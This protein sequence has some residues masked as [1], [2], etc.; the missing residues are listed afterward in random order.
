MKEAFLL[1]FF[2]AVVII[3]WVI[4]KNNNE[5]FTNIH[6]KQANFVNRQLA[7]YGHVPIPL[8]TSKK[9]G[10]LGETGNDMLRTDDYKA[11]YPLT[12]KDG[13]WKIVD[14][15]E[16]IKV[17]DCSAFDDPEFSLNCGICLD[18][19]KN[20]ANAPAVGG[21]VLLPA[22]KKAARDGN[23]SNFIPEYVPTL[24][25]CPA[26]KLVST[27]EECLQAQ[28]EI[29]CEKNG[30]FDIPGCA[31][32][33]SDGKFSIVDSDKPG[34]VSGYGRILVV[35]VGILTIR[36]EGFD[37]RTNINLS[38][39]KS[40][41]FDIRATEGKTVKFSLTPP[42]KSTDMN[43][44]NPYIAG[45]MIGRT[46]AGEWTQ[47]LRQIVIIDE[48]TGRKPRSTGAQLLN[49]VN[50]VKMAP[51]FGQTTMTISLSIPF[52]F[53][54][55]T[56]KEASLCKGSPFITSQASANF[57]ES[58]PC[59]NKGSGPGKYSQECLQNVWIT[60]GC[61]ISGKSYPND[62][63]TNAILMTAED[64]SF[65]TINDI[66]DYIYNLAIITATG[67]DQSG[68]KQSIDGWSNASYECTGNIITSPCDLPNSR[69]NILSPDC[70]IYLWNNQ[71][72]KKLWN[73][74][75]SPIGPTYYTSDAVSLFKRGSTLRACQT[76]GTLS[77]VSPNGSTKN[78]IVAYWQSKGDLNTVKKLMADL[79]RAANAQA[80]ADDKLAPYF[81]QC[82][83]NVDFAKPV[84]YV[85][86]PPPP[87][88]P[89]KTDTVKPY[90]Q[91]L[92][93]IIAQHCDN[94][95]WKR[96]LGLGSWKSI[97]HY[98]SDISYITV[99]IGITANLTTRQG[100]SH[101]IYGPGVFNFCTKGGFNDNV[102]DILVTRQ[103]E[104]GNSYSE[105]STVIIA[106]HCNNT[107]WKKTFGLGTWKSVTHYPSD[108]SYITV[109]IGMVANL[110][111]RQGLS[112]TVY[113]PGEFNFCT[114][115]GFNDNVSSILI[116]RQARF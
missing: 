57:L 21:L 37:P 81:T 24:G 89:P 27:K 68:K 55:T 20:H 108:V 59:Y 51:G 49:G 50:T 114:K 67:I 77:P 72:S 18:I 94:T 2:L 115:E 84:P 30:S 28:R 60:N 48:V 40:F 96:T 64:G 99:P 6:T 73:G 7:H 102:S 65:R 38:P 33:Y 34:I 85:A 104:T 23:Q 103:E 45:Y 74:Q 113:G 5:G 82:Y 90:L 11:N 91:E 76:T 3:T 109:P 46:F 10:A 43:P 39:N 62:T 22:D 35:G 93:V 12:Q 110:T 36:E 8:I 42:P 58:D 111:T 54:E 9:W 95:G 100:L 52:T 1:L 116:T 78:D 79:H 31:Q 80:V 4:F 69:G 19:G 32:C 14:K 92:S 16:S 75:D 41:A 83:G 101:T 71:G 63:N 25:F 97:T 105:E 13:I 86:P 66:S 107:G 29:L 56:T 17:M 87:P 70:I 88:L 15:C 47:D 44:I 53:V 61:T 112:H 106:Q 98:P 26:R